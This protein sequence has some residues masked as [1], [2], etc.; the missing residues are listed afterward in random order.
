[1][2]LSLT[3]ALFTVAA[4]CVFL[5]S[6]TSPLLYEETIPDFK[7]PSDKALCVVIRPMGI[8]GQYAPLW[9]DTKCVGG[10]IGNTI[11][12]FEVD[13]GS[14]LVMTKINLMSKTK[15]N[16][17]SGRIYYV[18]MAAYPIPMVGTGTSLTPMPGSEATAKIEEEQGKIKFTKLNP[19]YEHKDLDADDLKEELDDYAEWEKKEP[20]KAR[21]EAE[22]PG[23]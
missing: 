5:V 23:Y 14:H 11:T 4:F 20:E 19:E 1:M 9:L 7:A 6:C 21:A 22:Y 13:P 18:L 16:F 8:Y 3:R 17:Q 12:S 15:L 10:T 2:I